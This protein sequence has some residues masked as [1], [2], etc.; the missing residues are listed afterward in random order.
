MSVLSM[1]ED[2]NKIDLNG[3]FHKGQNEYYFNC[4]SQTL[5]Y[6][7]ILPSLTSKIEKTRVY[8]YVRWTD[9]I[10]LSD[11]ITVTS[12]DISSVKCSIT[13][14]YMSN[15]KTNYK[16]P[17]D[18]VFTLAEKLHSGDILHKSLIDNILTILQVDKDTIQITLDQID[19]IKLSKIDN[20]LHI[21]LI[22]IF[23]KRHRSLLNF[24]MEIICEF[25]NR[26]STIY[27]KNFI[28]N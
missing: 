16:T 25:I 14:L 17:L 6:N 7:T 12:N 28:L 22:P 23:S 11:F 20:K 26:N 9:N 5:N 27:I 19:S 13:P 18:A 15:E 24:M 1:Y 8:A 10:D 2:N 3:F 21:T 4:K